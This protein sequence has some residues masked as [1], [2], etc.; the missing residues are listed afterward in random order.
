[1]L[2]EDRTPE[3]AHLRKMVRAEGYEVIGI[4]SSGPEAIAMADRLRPQLILIRAQIPGPL[5]GIDTI[6]AI[7]ARHAVRVVYVSSCSDPALL[8]RA[9]A[10]GADGFIV[11]PIVGAQIVSALKVAMSTGPLA[12]GPSASASM[13]SPDTWKEMVDRVNRL[14]E[15][16]Q[17]LQSG[18]THGRLSPREAEL[19]R[20]LIYYRHLGLA[21]EVMDISLHTA[22]NHLKSVFRKLN[23]HSQEELF[24]QLVNWPRT[25]AT[26]TSAKGVALK[27]YGHIGSVVQGTALDAL[28][29]PSRRQSGDSQTA[30]SEADKPLHS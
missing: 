15:R 10:A 6:A 12:D 16:S 28:V 8:E 3:V 26:A 24:R 22:R 7:R 30:A 13:A 18:S 1:M 5:D 20:A 21:A 9:I 19:V 4:A 29:G 23:V 2:V 27:T 17:S 14:A 11:T 25:A